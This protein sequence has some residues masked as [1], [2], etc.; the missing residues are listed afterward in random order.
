[1]FRRSQVNFL[2]IHKLRRLRRRLEQTW[3]MDIG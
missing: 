2:L 1:M 3:D